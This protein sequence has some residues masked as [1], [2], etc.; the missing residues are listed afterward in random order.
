MQ[1]STI[2]ALGVGAAVVTTGA[3]VYACNP[4]WQ[5]TRQP[6]DTVTGRPLTLAEQLQRFATATGKYQRRDNPSAEPGARKV[7]IVAASFT[8]LVPGVTRATTLATPAL[9]HDGF[10]AWKRMMSNAG[11][12]DEDARATFWLYLKETA[13]G[14]CC[15]GRN[16]GNRKARPFANATT[17]LA[18]NDPHVYDTNPLGNGVYLLVDQV[19]SFDAYRTFPTWEDSLRD[20]KRLFSIPLYAQHDVLGGYRRGGLQGLKDAITAMSDA[21]YSPGP[22]AAKRVECEQFWA[23]AIARANGTDPRFARRAGELPAAYIARVGE[24]AWVR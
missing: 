7:P 20:E 3:V 17:I 15:W 1:R 18:P 10:A 19:R 5:P 11:R 2:V 12:G 9:F 13:W 8:P 14:K 22:A 4:L 6:M 16:T 23:M 21:G 24:G